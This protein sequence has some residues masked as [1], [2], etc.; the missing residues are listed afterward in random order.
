[1]V[2]ID[3]NEGEVTID[4]DDE[5]LEDFIEREEQA[6][7]IHAEAREKAQEPAVTADGDRVEVVANVGGVMDAPIGIKNG[8]EGV[9]LLRTEFIYLNRNDF[10][11]EAEQIETYIAIFSYYIDMPVIVRALDIGGDKDLPYL[12]QPEETNPF[13]GWRGVRMLEEEKDMYKTQFRALLQAGGKAQVDLH[14][15]MPMV[16]GLEEIKQSKDLME[17]VR[18]ELEEEGKE[19][20]D[21]VKFGIMIEVPSAALLADRLA[22]EVDFFSI[23][24]NDLTQYTLA[25]DR[26]NRKVANLANPLNPAV[27][28]LIKKTIDSAHAEGKWVGLCG[29]MAGDPLA[30]PILLGLGL[31]EFSMAPSRIPVIKQ[32]LRQLKKEDCISLAEEALETDSDKAV[33]ELCRSFLA[34]LGLD[35]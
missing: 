17:E 24:T 28:S 20:P 5:T 8:A 31:D 7:E 35:F 15:M 25:V 10:P 11:S 22:R 3:G 34:E 12:D 1:M 32:V 18:S 33:Q 29:E 13:L 19:L 27:L 30:T 14:I 26:T 9:G 4:P 16:A 23:G 21:D 2:L 6:E